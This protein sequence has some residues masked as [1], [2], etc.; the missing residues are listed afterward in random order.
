MTAYRRS[1]PAMI[2]SVYRLNTMANTVHQTFGKSIGF[3]S[4]PLI[5]PRTSGMAWSFFDTHGQRKYLTSKERIAFIEAAIRVGGHTGTFCLLLALTGARISEA[6]QL[7]PERIDVSNEA[8]VFE[9]LKRRKRGVFRAVPVPRGLIDRLEAEHSFRLK[10]NDPR[11]RN[12]CLW[13][14][15]RTT[16]WKRV[17]YVAAMARLNCTLVKPKALRHAF[18]IAA[19]QDRIA[20]TLVKKWLGHAKIETTAIYAEP[21][22]DE[23]RALA[24]LMWGKLPTSL[25]APTE[26]NGRF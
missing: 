23:E 6:L 26:S 15:S 5:K 22:G 11:A 12:A 3:S 9:T 7:T 24:R 1:C 13:N 14:W 8:I 20:L 21:I 25:G 4:G 16:A 10:Q 2:Y 17:K 18:G 19:V